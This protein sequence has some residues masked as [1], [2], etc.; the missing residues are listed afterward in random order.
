MCDKKIS[1]VGAGMGRR[2]FLA[3]GSP[4]F[5]MDSYIWNNPHT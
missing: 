5:Q 4:F 3:A 1:I 2:R